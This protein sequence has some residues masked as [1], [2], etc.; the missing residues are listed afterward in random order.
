MVP[1]TQSLSVFQFSSITH[2]TIHSDF[3]FTIGS[4]VDIIRDADRCF[5]NS[6]Q[7]LRTGCA[8][9]HQST[10]YS[11]IAENSCSNTWWCKRQTWA[12]FL[13]F[14]SFDQIIW[15][16][17]A[18]RLKNKN[19]LK[20]QAYLTIGIILNV[21]SASM[22]FFPKNTLPLIRGLF[23]YRSAEWADASRGF[24]PP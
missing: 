19:S 10:I 8:L 13:I 22:S 9:V 6:V 14:L 17:F 7:T 4:D 24:G 18:S 11:P 2:C 15:W 1:S 12:Y 21:N 20:P 5:Q 3:N 23:N 16:L